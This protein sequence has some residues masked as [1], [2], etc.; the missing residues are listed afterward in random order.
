MADT[1]KV[2]WETS[3]VKDLGSSTQTLKL[4]DETY[5]LEYTSYG[6]GTLEVEVGISDFKLLDGGKLLVAMSDSSFQVKVGLTSNTAITTKLFS[7]SGDE[8]EFFFTNPDVTNDISIKYMIG[9]N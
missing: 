1:I 5:E 3:L 2:D 4:Q 9:T 8:T 7:Y 6:E